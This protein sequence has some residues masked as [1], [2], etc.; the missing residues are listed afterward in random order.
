MPYWYGTGAKPNKLL[1]SGRDYIDA[2]PLDLAPIRWTDI[3]GESWG[4]LSFTVM[5]TTANRSLQGGADVRLRVNDTDVF[6]GTLIRKRLG[7]MP[8]AGRVIECECVSADSWLDWRIVPQWSSRTDLG[9]RVRKLTSDRA[10]VK[11][12]VER[13]GGPLKATNATVTET[14]TGMD[15]VRAQK[16]TLREALEL[17][18]AEA[19]SP[20]SPGTRRMYV[21]EQYRVHWYNGL[22]GTAAPYRIA[23]GSYVRDVLT[24]AGLVEYWSLREEGGTTSYGSQGVA[25]VTQ[26]GGWT[27][28][29]TNIGDVND[30]AYRAVTLDGT[31]DYGTATGATLTPGD[32]FTLELWFKRAGTGAAV[33]IDATTASDYRLDFTAGDAIRLLKIGGATSFT[34][35]PTYTDTSWHHLVMAHDAT[36]TLLYVDGASVAGTGTNQTFVDGN[37]TI[38]IG[39][40]SAGGTLFAGSL[41]H[42][43]IYSVKNS[44]ATALAHYRQGISIPPEGLWLDDEWAKVLHHAYVV[45]STA[46]KDDAGSGWVYNTGSDFERGAVQDFVEREQSNTR[47]E[48]DRAGKHAIR[49]RSKVRGI[50][51]QTDV[52]AA[53]RSG[54]TLT[55]TDDSFGLAGD[56]FEIRAVNG[57]LGPGSVATFDIEAG[58]LRRRLTRHARRRRNR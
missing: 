14:N 34:S 42:I 30:R 49:V 23:D 32:T 35:T 17:V 22:E 37:G 24:T 54:Q 3:A 28:G 26:V 36:S 5:D 45:G 4:G 57:E 58:A 27:Q 40:T 44:N 1:V 31:A 55:V 47:A 39:G 13:R 2:V 20:A 56:T 15:V 33:L 25:N 51:F 18:A 38:G 12:L 8:G 16:V 50:T 9:N 43:A 53:W 10:M 52:A 21:D 29:V 48:R 46:K 11:D 19:Q 41:Q 7:R 6:A